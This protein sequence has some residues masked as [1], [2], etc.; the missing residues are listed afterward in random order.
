MLKLNKS[1]RFALYSIVE[2]SRDPEVVRSVK[3]ISDKYGISEHH[4]A[5]VLQQLVRAGM[6][7]SIRGI[8]GG[9]QI[10]VDPK[11]ITML[12]IIE[13][14]EPKTPTNG[15]VLLEQEETCALPETC[16]IGRV[17]AEIQEQ[18]YYTLKSVSIATLLS[19]KKIS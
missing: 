14:F 17:F 5:K 18:A 2:L 3:Q 10:A 6:I 15:C 4:V 11:E 19:P 7:R 1:T 12:D 13:L 16:A 9:F 8:G